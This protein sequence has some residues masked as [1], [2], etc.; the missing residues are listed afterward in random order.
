METQKKGRVIMTTSDYL[1]LAI[2]RQREQEMIR[3]L[4][5]RRVRAERAP[6]RRDADHGILGA[7]SVRFNRLQT[8]VRHQTVRG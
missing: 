5:R 8:A 7:L 2:Y 1:A 6:A 3:N 4:E